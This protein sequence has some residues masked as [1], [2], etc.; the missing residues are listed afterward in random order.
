MQVP[1]PQI[2]PLLPP[3]TPLQRSTL[4]SPT[5]LNMYQK[6]APHSHSQH[7]PTHRFFWSRCQ[8]PKYWL[9]WIFTNPL[10]PPPPPQI[11]TTKTALES[12]QIQFCPVLSSQE[13]PLLLLS[14]QNSIYWH[15]TPMSVEGLSK[16]H[17]LDIGA[18]PEWLGLHLHTSPPRLAC[19]PP[20]C[21]PHPH[22][23]PARIGLG[24]WSSHEWSC[25]T[26]S[27]RC[28]DARPLGSPSCGT[29][30]V[31]S[32]C[33]VHNK[34]K[35]MLLNSSV[36]TQKTPHWETTIPKSTSY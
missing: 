18:W 14:W 3:I 24:P 26:W 15:K 16:T 19:T 33:C 29:C 27:R 23:C 1:L 22:S 10:S 25:A 12:P 31:L 34:D 7:Q 2:H 21:P 28:R 32:S 11:T 13:G 35:I 17:L 4:H 8:I 20:H 9:W 36:S 5:H 30:R 6:M